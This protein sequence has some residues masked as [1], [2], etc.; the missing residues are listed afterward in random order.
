VQQTAGDGPGPGSRWEVV[1]RPSRLRPPRRM[2][3]ECVDWDPPARVAWR[4]DD[5]VD[6]IDVAYELE[7]VWT[8]T[9]ITQRD[10]ARLGAPRPFRALYGLGIRRDMNRGLRELEAILERRPPD[11]R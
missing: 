3:Y 6:E 11:A 10:D 7:P 9:R 2:A 5:G 1:H 4:G 8:S